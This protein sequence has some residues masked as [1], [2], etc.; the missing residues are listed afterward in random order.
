MKGRTSSATL[1]EK[2]IPH[3]GNIKSKGPEM[4]TQSAC[5]GTARRQHGWNGA[6]KEPDHKRAMNELR[7]E[8]EIVFYV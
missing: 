1:W 2:R 5:S 8:V 6:S 4:G 3:T 7:L